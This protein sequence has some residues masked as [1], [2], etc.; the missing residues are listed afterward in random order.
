[1]TPVILVLNVGSSSIKFATYPAAG[2]EAPILRGKIAGIGTKPEFTLRE[3]PE[4]AG[5][6]GPISAGE[7]QEPLINRLLAWLDAEPDLGSVVG[8]GHRVVH[9]GTS[10]A[11]PVRI[12]ARVLATLSAL[13]PLAPLHQP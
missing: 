10:Y 12:D 6:F 3:G 4:D 11:A 8:V 5:A 1:M 13:E 2:D 7:G 9:G